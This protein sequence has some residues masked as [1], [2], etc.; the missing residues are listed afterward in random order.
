MSIMKR[1]SVFLASTIV[2]ALL[3]FGCSGQPPPTAVVTNA[4]PEFDLA[5]VNGNGSLTTADLKGKVTVMDFW[6][7]WCEPCKTEIPK[8]NQLFDKYASDP[9]QMVGVTI[10]SG[11]AEDIKLNVE[12]LN[13]KYLVVVGDDNVAEGFGGVIGY[14]MT[15]LVNKDGTIYKKY[16]GA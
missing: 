6:A 11:S 8:F 12:E 13:M 3:A 10:Q 4:A 9:F 16:M 5:V 14:P 1:P 15:F 7:T 2:I